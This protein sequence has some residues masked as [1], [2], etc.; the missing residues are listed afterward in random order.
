MLDHKIEDRMESFF[1][2]ETTKYLYL[3]F[4]P[5][6]FI[7]N[8]GSCGE[9]IQMSGGNC[10]IGAGG[11]VF[12]TE[13]HPIDIGA[14]YCCSARHH[15]HQLHLY[16]FQKNM[17]L[18]SLLEIS[19]NKEF[20]ETFKS[21]Q[22]FKGKNPKRKLES[23]SSL[24]PK[25]DSDEV[26]S[27]ISHYDLNSTVILNYFLNTTYAI[28][29]HYTDNLYD[30]VQQPSAKLSSNENLQNITDTNSLLMPLNISLQSNVSILENSNTSFISSETELT[31]NVSIKPIITD[32]TLVF[33]HTSFEDSF[34]FTLEEQLKSEVLENIKSS[35]SNETNVDTP[36]TEINLNFT[37][38]AIEIE[39]KDIISSS[40]NDP[41]DHEFY[42]YEL[43]MCPA[44]PFTARLNIM[45]EMF[46][47]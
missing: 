8:N 5:D 41:Y 38:V 42:K 29:D 34:N 39:E 22:R 19:D 25:N 31:S 37:G 10:I 43:L 28:E 24:C 44:Q 21:K 20:F 12:N 33:N 27:N 26:D 4:D 13:A 46:N 6:N 14:V 3:L 40:L 15:D 23:I 45:G 16:E 18:H 47:V 30:S 2:A 32:S 7:H 17:D 35:L 9:L 36:S 1:L 11:Y